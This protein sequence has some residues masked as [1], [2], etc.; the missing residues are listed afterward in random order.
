MTLRGRT[1][2]GREALP[3]HGHQVITKVIIGVQ[4]CEL[5]KDSTAGWVCS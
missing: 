1:Q 5:T 3:T 4:A 2:L